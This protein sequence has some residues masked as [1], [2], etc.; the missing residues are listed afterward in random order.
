MPLK[1]VIFDF[2]GVLVRTQSQELRRRWEQR[3]GLQP[4][5]AEHIV[6]GGE[7]DWAVQLGR[8]SDADHWRWLGRRFGLSAACWWQWR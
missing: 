4:G 8:T 3:L 6:F 2:G 7:T 5:R 1:A